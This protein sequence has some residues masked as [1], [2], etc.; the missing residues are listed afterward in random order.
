MVRD[1]A[2]S[3]VSSSRRHV[4]SASRRLAIAVGHSSVE[5]QT[6]VAAAA[7]AAE[8]GTGNLFPSN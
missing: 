7:S 1:V 6:A 3:K 8:T 4:V 5:G 2:S